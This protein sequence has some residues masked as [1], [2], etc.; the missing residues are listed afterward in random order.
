MPY[1]SQLAQ[2]AH[3]HLGR[4]TTVNADN[5]CAGSRL[6]GGTKFLSICD[7]KTQPFIFQWR[8]KK[9]DIAAHMLL[10]QL[11][12][13]LQGRCEWLCNDSVWGTASIISHNWTYSTYNWIKSV[14][15][16]AGVVQTCAACSERER[17]SP[18]HG[19]IRR[20]TLYEMWTWFIHKHS[21]CH[22]DV[23]KGRS[24][25]MWLSFMYKDHYCAGTLLRMEKKTQQKNIISLAF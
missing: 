1:W 16:W 7:R 17:F 8:W 25:E 21:G 15:V 6:H 18:Q 22:K 10:C 13:K 14:S 20:A 2:S 3:F 5:M 23:T 12:P 11:N 19:A 9:R 24:G 4:Q